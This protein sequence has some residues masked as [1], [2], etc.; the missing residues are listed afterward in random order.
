M[1]DWYDRLT[2][3]I[4]YLMSALGM[5]LSK[6]TFEQWYFVLSLV[7]GV[8]ALGLNYWHKRNM[9]KIAKERG[10]TIDVG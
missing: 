5:T 2:A 3:G 8:I 7:I 1:K 10:V 4:A 6:L 9:Q